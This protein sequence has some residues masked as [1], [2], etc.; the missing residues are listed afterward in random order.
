MGPRGGYVS[1]CHGLLCMK[2]GIS[3]V[4]YALTRI[5][6]F[7][8]ERPIALNFVLRTLKYLHCPNYDQLLAQNKD[9]RLLYQLPNL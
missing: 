8:E 1:N 2:F 9:S 6:W 7:K 4:V 5:V 3:G